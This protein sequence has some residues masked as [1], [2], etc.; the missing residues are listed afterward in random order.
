MAEQIIRALGTEWRLTGEQF[1]EDAAKRV[2]IGVRANTLKITR[3]LLRCHVVQAAHDCTS[4]CQS[5]K[6]R[7]KL[8]G[9]LPGAA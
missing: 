6:V 7:F 3:R 9:L 8:F 5:I 2:H 1:V 4:L